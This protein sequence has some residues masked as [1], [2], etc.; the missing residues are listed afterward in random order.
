MLMPRNTKWV[1]ALA[2]ILS[3]LPSLGQTPGAG[4]GD[5]FARFDLPDD[6]EDRFWASP[7]AKALLKLSPKAIADL[8]P[9]QAG[10]R[11]CRCPNCDAREDD[12]PLAWS[13]DTPKSL[14]CKVCQAV[15]PEPAKPAADPAKPHAEPAKPVT[16]ETI[17][18]LPRIVHHYPYIELPEIKQHYPGERLYLAAKADYEA[19]EFLAK[20]ALYAAVRH[21]EQTA[22]AKDPALAELAALILI[23]FARVYPAYATHYDQ[24]NTPKFLQ[25][26]DLAPPYRRGYK[27]AKW[28]WNGSLNVP[29]NLVVAYALIRDDPAIEKAAQFLDVENPRALIERDLFRSA[30]EFT[31]DQPEEVNENGLQATRGILA[32]GRLLDDPLLIADAIKRL[33]RFSQAGFYHDGFWGKGTRVA[34]QRVMS[35]LDGWIERLLVGFRPPEQLASL[36]KVENGSSELRRLPLLALARE[37]GSAIL[38]EPTR[39]D[40]EV[41]SWPARPV[42][43]ESRGP[44]LLGGT[45]IARLSVGDGPQGLDLELRGLDSFGSGQI[46]RQTLRLAA[47][48]KILLGDLDDGPGLANGFD[49][50]SVSHNT[51][52]VDGLNQRESL[53]Q[54]R[55]AASGGDF[56]FFAADPDFQVATHDDPRSY[57]RSTKRYRQTLIASAGPSNRYAVSVFEVNGG[58]QH[59]QFFHG[60]ADSAARWR[61]ALATTPRPSSLLPPS[62][63]YVPDA[64]A[65]NDRWFVQSQGDFNELA[66][67]VTDRPTT[68]TLLT[69]SETQVGTRL[70]L[71]TSGSSRLITA[72][73]PGASSG[74][75]RGSLVI[76]KRSADG[77]NLDTTFVTVFEPL[78]GEIPRLKRVGRVASSESTV[79]IYLETADGPESIIV[80]LN[81]GKPCKVELA[82]GRVFSMDGL[83]ARVRGHALVLAGGTFAET[84]TARV[85]QGI[86]RGKILA[87]I[88]KST[89]DSCG[90]FETDATL[91]NPEKL[92]GRILLI[93]HGDGTTR[94]WTIHSAQNT[95][96]GARVFVREEPGFRIDAKSNEARYYQFPQSNFKGPHT[97]RISM[98]A[99]TETR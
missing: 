97:F 54:A 66:E 2:M 88:R 13:I 43:A 12:D 9:E 73:S 98:I 7:N 81:P 70:H 31:K 37:A 40:V 77:S 3:P 6:W 47:G 84:G 11:Y 28:D 74:Q 22:T 29:L 89:E 16:E 86:A 1:I 42:I 96:N 19:R 72:V 53:L 95:E 39:S 20:A 87:A 55:I 25:K 82:D 51:V 78:S 68:A 32:A 4:V 59:D 92:A 67:T 62:I 26:A 58:L 17:E 80:N 85:E 71:L 10:F 83:A 64:P 14:K 23:R 76:R 45:G 65:D 79:V 91:P 46:Q 38:T 49:R 30:A 63:T 41:V 21:H 94:G 99:R 61:L 5:P 69:D 56:V 93:A 36:R 48:G 60:P 8:V 44:K 90:L 50:S 57:P 34:H 24:L 75:A 18:V 33:D 52:V 15:V 27:T 35:Q